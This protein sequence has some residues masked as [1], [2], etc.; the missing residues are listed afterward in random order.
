MPTTFHFS[1]AQLQVLQAMQ[2][3]LKV[4]PTGHPHNTRGD[5]TFKTHAARMGCRFQSNAYC[6]E[7]GKENYFMSHLTLWIESRDP[8]KKIILNSGASA[9][10]FNGSRLLNNIE[11]GTFY[12]IKTGYQ[13]T[14]LPIKGWESVKLT[15]GKRKIQ[16]ENCLLVPEIVINL[17]S[18]GV[19]QRGSILSQRTFHSMSSK[20][21]IQSSKENSDMEYSP[22][23]I[24][25]ALADLTLQHWPMSL[26]QKSH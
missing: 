6:T 10:I 3:R 22:L 7:K 2:A 8:K 11:M 1:P 20:I 5:H 19:T 17:I 25:A 4:Q 24:L 9:H 21:G 16:L 23:T 12:C 26:N 14:N 13:G 15:W 18:T